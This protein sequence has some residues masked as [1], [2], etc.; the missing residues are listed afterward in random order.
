MKLLGK[1]QIVM[2]TGCGT[3]R[4]DDKHYEITNAMGGEMVVHSKQ[5]GQSFM[6]D[7]DTVLELAS[8]AGIDTPLRDPL[9]TVDFRLI[10]AGVE[11]KTSEATPECRRCGTVLNDQGRCADVTCPFHDCEQNDQKGWEGFPEVKPQI[12]TF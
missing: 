11:E 2:G 7:W 4:K 9:A 3:A 1:N 5:T 8:E 6:I 12:K 10:D